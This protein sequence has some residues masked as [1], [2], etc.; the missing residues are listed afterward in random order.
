LQDALGALN[1]LATHRD[2]VGDGAPL[3][4]LAHSQDRAEALLRDAEQAFG[5]FAETKAF[6]KA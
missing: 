6:W 2:L 4:P 5:R 1:D 3:A